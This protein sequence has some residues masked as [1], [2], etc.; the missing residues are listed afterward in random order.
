MKKICFI[1]NSGWAI[2]NFRS[3][4][5]DC[6]AEQNYQI[7]CI[8]HEDKFSNLI[9]WP[10]HNLM[11]HPQ[12]VNLFKQ[13]LSMWRLFSHLR[14]S[15]YDLLNVYTIRACLE[16]AFINIFIRKKV[17]L[18]I[19]G[20]GILDR[21][22]SL[23]LRKILILI[24]KYLFKS[25][26]IRRFIFQ[27]AH[28][29]DFFIQHGICLEEYTVLV[30]GSGV[31]IKPYKEKNF[32]RE[33]LSFLHM[34]RLI[35]SKGVE[36]YC[37][38]AEKIKERYDLKFFLAGEFEDLDRNGVSKEFVKHHHDKGNIEYL[39][40]VSDVGEL[41]NKTHVT[42][43][44]T[45]Y[46]EGIPKS[47]I[48][49]ASSGNIIISSNQPGCLEVVKNGYNGY[50]IDTSTNSLQEKIID[51]INMFPQERSELSRNSYKIASDKFDIDIVNAIYGE[52]IG[53]L[54]NEDK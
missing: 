1:S 51:I 29:R 19:T 39:G 40:F 34:S 44:L 6:L 36:Q 11:G 5:M 37:E 26:N 20:L 10:T 18:N 50:V 9:K 33:N 21:K 23:F 8:V 4:L 38:A 27:S 25:K 15:N 14:I 17:I 24:S 2:Y 49:S 30:P 16:V 35:R 46:P 47:L 43:L 54:L 41:L 3:K 32:E 31:E 52:V 22:E 7:E 12:S 42:V 28:D 45:D 13:T 48:E 53:E